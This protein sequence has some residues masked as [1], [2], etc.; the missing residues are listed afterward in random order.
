[1]LS[2]FTIIVEELNMGKQL[3]VFDL[4][5]PERWYIDPRLCNTEI[6]LCLTTRT[7]QLRS[8]SRS[9]FVL[10]WFPG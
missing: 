3:H 9:E 4:D 6:S 2:A 1:V 5:S 10:W 8:S 7:Y